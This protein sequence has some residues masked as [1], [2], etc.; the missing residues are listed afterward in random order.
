LTDEARVDPYDPAQGKRNIMI[1]LFYPIKRSAC[2]QT[3]QVPYMPPKTTAFLDAGLA[4]YRIPRIF[5]SIKLQICTEVVEEASK[6]VGKFPVVLLSPG[7]TFTRHQYNAMAQKLASTGYAVVTIDHAFETIIVEYPDGTHTTGKPPTHWDPQD[8]E[9]HEA[10]LSTRA[11]DARFVL[12]QLGDLNVVKKLVPG[13]TFPFSI[14]KAAIFG[15][16]F[17]GT[18]AISTLMRD[19]RFVGAINIDGSQYGPLYDTTHPVLLFGRGEPSPRNRS[20]NPTW[21]PLWAHLKGWKKEVNL[22]NC[23]HT[24]FCDTPLLTKLSGMQSMPV[25]EK[26][27]GTI[28][29]ER[30][31]EVVMGIV[32]AFMDKALKGV[33][34]SGL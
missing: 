8:K 34:S 33:E 28:D 27:L 14:D 17:G 24:T 13:A 31:F 3:S 20:N 29:G 30:A 19:S 10:L 22:K 11:E 6:D 9:K 1:S 16:S 15:H 12:T 7:L 32:I 26:M 2:M 25:M 23:E 18:T 4:Q 21:Q 5:G